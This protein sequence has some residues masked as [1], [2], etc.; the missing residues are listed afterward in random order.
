MNIITLISLIFFTKIIIKYQTNDSYFLNFIM[1]YLYFYTKTSSYK[2]SISVSLL[3]LFVCT[4]TKYMLDPSTSFVINTGILIWLFVNYKRVAR[5]LYPHVKN[6]IFFGLTY[7]Y[8]SFAE[9]T[10]HKYVMHCN[11]KSFFWS[12][13]SGLDPTKIINDICDHHIEHHL[14]VNPNMTLSEVKH[15]TSLFMGWRVCVQ[16][17][18]IVFIGMVITKFI[19]GV[20]YSYGLLAISSIIISM[21]WSYLWNKVHPLMHNFMGSYKINEGPY[22]NKIDFSIINKLFYR[23]HQFHHLQK[24]VKKGNYNVIVF[25]ADEWL[26]TNVQVIDNKEYCSNPQTS[27]ESICKSL[28]GSALV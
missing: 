22:E 5:L 4:F 26:G 13:I 18:I 27:G 3:Y 11:K 8:F 15:K 9:W 20:K 10:I 16:V 17:S 2:I 28:I 19:S 25:G 7:I 14:E 23:N 6:I 1:V 21:T 24:G 12:I